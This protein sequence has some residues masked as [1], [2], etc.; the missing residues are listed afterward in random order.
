MNTKNFNHKNSTGFK[1]PEGYFQNLEQ[2]LM[3]KISRVQEMPANS[4][5]VAP[6]D[7]FNELEDDI[8]SKIHE[9]DTK[10]IPLFKKEYWLYASAVAAI[11]IIALGNFWVDSPSTNTGWDDIEITALENYLDESY[12][13]GSIDLNSIEYSGL[14]M[15]GDLEADFTDINKE[16]AFEYIDQNVE[17]PS[18]IME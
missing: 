7:Y 18:Y 11:L 16:A 15:E 3:K 2:D 13:M 1:T 14:L 5:F 6:K 17:D 12:E 4:G 8:L 9:P 10:V